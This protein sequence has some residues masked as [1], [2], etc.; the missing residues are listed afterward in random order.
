MGA[1][2][3]AP[4]HRIGL[5]L[6]KRCWDA[7]LR[8]GI[9]LSDRWS[10]IGKAIVGGVVL[11]AVVIG[12]GLS[13]GLSLAQSIAAARQELAA[14][15]SLHS[16]MNLL[17]D[18]AHLRVTDGA[19]GEDGE[20]ARADI[21]AR[22]KAWAD[23]A[24]GASE[25]HGR[26]VRAADRLSGLGAGAEAERGFMAHA[27]LARELLA[28][29]EEE[30]RRSGMFGDR[31]VDTAAFA[32]MRD[33]PVLIETAVKQ[34]EARKVP[35]RELGIYA[36]GAQLIV[37]DGIE[38]IRPVLER[39]GS[40]SATTAGG[41]ADA[42]LPGLFE[43]M[44]RQ[45]QSAVDDGPSGG[46]RVPDPYPMASAFIFGGVLREQVENHWRRRIE[47]QYRAGLRTAL[48]SVL[49]TLACGYLVLGTVISIRRS[50]QALERG[51]SEF[52]DDSHLDVRISIDTQDE[53]RHVAANFNRMAERT[54]DLL[55]E[56]EAQAARARRDLETQVEERTRDLSQANRRLSETVEK[57]TM[58]QEELVRTGK[59]AAL[60]T[61]VAGVAH[62]VNTPLG[63]A[64]TITT[65]MQD[66]AH[67]LA[68][69][70]HA[71][72]LKAPDLASY[73]DA[74]NDG[75]RHAASNLQRAATL[76]ENFKQ[77]AAD[78]STDVRRSFDLETYV[79]EVVASLGSV[80]RKNGHRVEIAAAD[81]IAMDS[82]PGAL[83][84]VIT[85]LVMN[86]VIHGFD[87]RQ[88][89]T[90]GIAINREGQDR[91]SMLVS[92][93]GRGM[94]ENVVARI[95]EPFFTT[96]RGQGGTGLG[97]HIVYNLVT[98]CL[99]GRISCISVP[100]KGSTFVVTLPTTAPSNSHDGP[101]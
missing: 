94:T 27:A 51:S 73:L 55:R 10:Y 79:R 9:R 1:P 41:R 31:E 85:N 22:S 98:G 91:C 25:I 66:Q 39:M 61:L 97:M 17:S 4:G 21:A 29:L 32:L 49:A 33:L 26:I 57:L 74:T 99:G 72:Q 6:G 20:R 83:A 101:A 59:M 18:L 78:Q 56:L 87:G 30:G 68:E 82:Y 2:D 24:C 58:A 28:C 13:Y 3:A 77:V 95:F 36:A 88:G 5:T 70:Y 42:R 90:I 45:L 19:D 65:H 53:F 69:K 93:D 34:V 80:L 64:Y 35:S 100:G 81:K 43:A 16:S 50:L 54:A 48:L 7:F 14:L 37:T 40:G 46:A 23:A 12:G 15:H 92:D 75:F 62:E 96:R 44:E 52:C 60:G 76:I 38:R 86:A 63:L 71:G 67:A 84:Q 47:R 8:P 89:G 11:A